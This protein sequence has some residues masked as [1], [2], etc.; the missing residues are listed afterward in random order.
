[1]R[2]RDAQGGEEKSGWLPW[3]Y[4]N[5]DDVAKYFW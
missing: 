4:K 2:E 1:M 5:Y 3:F